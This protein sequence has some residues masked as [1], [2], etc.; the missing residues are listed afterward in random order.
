MSGEE[1]VINVSYTRRDLL[2]YAVGIGC[3]EL[4]FVYEND[5]NFA[6][7]PTYAI[8]LPF[9]GT[10]NDV[11]DFPSAA[12]M[13]ANVMPGLP[14][15]KFVLDGERYL[16]VLRPIPP[17]PSTFQ[18]RSKLVGVHP[19]PKGA[20]VETIAEVVDSSGVVYV[21][22]VSGTF[23][24]GAKDVADSGTT[25]SQAVETPKRAPDAVQEMRTSPTQAHLYRLSGDYNPLHIDPTMAQMNGFPQPILHGLCTFGHAARAVL[26]SFAE[27]NPQRFRAIRCRFASP[28]T[29][30]DT[31]VTEMWKEGD[32]IIYV[33]KVKETGKVVI[34][35]AYVDLSPE[36]KL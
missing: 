30:G 26:K 1:S 2:L 21:R 17:T 25:Y 19:K 13:Q 33:T 28:V 22:I 6:A 18:I 16:E 10:E 8:V 23:V 11:V 27:S 34:N 35:N 31:L 36:S 7:F 32:R 9:K 24:V 29:P 15:M 3:D 14:G 4:H 20:L 5:P 12:M